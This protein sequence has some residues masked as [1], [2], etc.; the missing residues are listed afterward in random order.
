M[1]CDADKALIRKEIVHAG[2]RNVDFKPGT[3]VQF[4]YVTKTCDSRA[5]VI[6]DSRVAGQPMELVLGKSFKLECWEVMVQ[7][8]AVGE[9]AR[10]RVDKSVGIMN[11]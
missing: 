9:V 4:H 10:F 2:T 3:K 8:M 5:A 7:K 11:C 6:D 1:S